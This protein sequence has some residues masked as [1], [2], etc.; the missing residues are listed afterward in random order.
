MFV[1]ELIAIGSENAI[2]EILQFLNENPTPEGMAEA[3]LMV[4]EKFVNNP[5]DPKWDTTQSRNLSK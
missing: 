2:I 3:K 4:L 5:M 1:Q